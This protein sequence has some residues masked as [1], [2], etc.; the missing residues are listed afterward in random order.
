[1]QEGDRGNEKGFG[2]RQFNIGEKHYKGICVI[3]NNLKRVFSSIIAV[4]LKLPSVTTLVQKV[5]MEKVKFPPL[6]FFR[7]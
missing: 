1:M 4:I 5:L 3:S 2:L 6:I 7:G